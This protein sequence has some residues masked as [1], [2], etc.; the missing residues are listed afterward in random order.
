[1]SFVDREQR[2]RDLL[3]LGEEALVVEALWRHVEKTEISG[4][5]PSRHV[6]RRRLVEA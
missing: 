5:E 6:A 4:A 2:N 3:E 1:M